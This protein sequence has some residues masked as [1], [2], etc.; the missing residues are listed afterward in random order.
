MRRIETGVTIGL[1]CGWL[2]GGGVAQ[3][4]AAGDAAVEIAAATHK[5]VFMR[6]AG[7]RYAPASFVRSGAAWT[8]FFDGGGPLLSGPSF[9][10]YPTTARLVEDTATRKA[11]QLAGEHASPPYAWEALVEAQPTGAFITVTVTCHLPAGLQ[12]SGAPEPTAA[13]WLAQPAVALTLDQGPMSIY[14]SY[15][16]GCPNGFGFPAAYLWDAG[17][18]A[19]VFVDFTPMT[20]MSLKGVARFFDC[21]VAAFAAGGRTGLGLHTFKLS[22]RAVPP[23]DLVVKY[24][25]YAAAR[26]VQPTKLEALDRMVRVCAPLHPAEPLHPPV[27]RTTGGAPTWTELSRCVLAQLTA[28]SRV[29]DTPIAPPWDDAPARLAAP[30]AS[31]RAVRGGWDFSILNNPLSA[32]LLF[33]R[34]T[35]DAAGL[36]SA[37]VMADG[38][39]LFYDPR[40]RMIRHGTRYPLHVGDREMSWQNFFFHVETLRAAAATPPEAFNP[41]VAGR[42]LM[43]TRGLKAYARNVDYVFAQWFDPYAHTAAMQNDVPELGEVREPWQGGSYAAVMVRAYEITGD[44]DYLREAAACLDALLRTMRYRVKN[45]LYDV[46]YDD[47][48]EFPIAELFGNAYGIVAAARL[49]EI[50]DNPNYRADAASFLNTLLRLTFWY[51]DEADPVARELGNL[52][53]FFPHGGAGTTTPW[54]NAEAHLGLAAALKYNVA[55]AHTEL[56]LKLLNLQRANAFYYFALATPD[57]LI[58]RHHPGV[59]PAEVRRG[60]FPTEPFYL[61]VEATG[62][63]NNFHAGYMSS[64]ALWNYWL[65]EALAAPSDPAMLVVNL[66][67]LDGYAEALAGL[68]RRF[69]VYNPTDRPAEFRLQLKSLPAAGV[70]A[71]V[72]GRDGRATATPVGPHG[73]VALALG[74]REFARLTVMHAD[75]EALKAELAATTKAQNALSHAYQRLQEVAR[76]QAGFAALAELK[77]QFAAAMS[78][79]GKGALASAAT[80]AQAIVGALCAVPVSVEAPAPRRVEPVI[81]AAAAA[82]A[83]AGP[84]N[85]ALASAGAVAFGKDDI[86]PG[87]GIAQVND[88]A[89][90]H[91]YA[92]WIGDTENNY[93]GVKLARAATVG[94]VAFSGNNVPG[95]V[96]EYR[97]TGAWQI[98][99]TTE[100]APSAASAW[101]TVLAVRREE[102]EGP[103]RKA[104]TFAP[105]ANVTAVRLTI[106]RAGAMVD[107]LEVY[108]SAPPRT[109]GGTTGA[110]GSNKL[111]R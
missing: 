59:S 74:P 65:Y 47:P 98:Q 107:E 87:Y 100:L 66:D 7:G 56:L 96:H 6:D 54:E 84:A 3:A 23:G 5:L 88:G 109:D 111:L 42:V 73:V 55:P 8:P 62:G 36:Q 50:T 95:G 61:S 104:Y 76:D 108:A 44:E 90:G 38:L 71:V 92:C 24:A 48:A 14:R 99:V 2:L 41:A 18:E 93:I 86:G 26:P 60:C 13:L 46:T 102:H 94:S 75:G 39:P 78:D 101:A 10:L 12:L 110:S 28:T 45:A 57:A 91:Q 52:G 105:V 82:P 58:Q 53:L 17:R 81:P 20:W 43:A 34:A 1:V 89:Y 80:Q 30:L 63:H 70:K 106:D 9:D 85:L 40:A 77:T 51:E 4:Q 37:L 16:G 97:F 33:T 103:G 35:D 27:D 11:V 22:G 25:V 64:Q 72:A 68:R 67:A 79:Y 49:A 21:K 83:P 29:E 19:V 15:R 31:M 69:M 32:S